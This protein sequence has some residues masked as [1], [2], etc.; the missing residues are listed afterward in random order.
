MRKYSNDGRG[1]YRSRDG[2]L[3]GVC[4]GVADYF[5]LS[6][7]WVRMAV[8]LVFLLSGFWPVLGVYLVAALLM[9][10]R[11]VRPIESEDEQEFYDSY[12]HS[13]RSAAQR[14]KRQFDNIDRRIRRMESTVTGKDYDWERRFNS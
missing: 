9:K 6:V 7:F 5:D 3:L 2:V 12:V 11:P 10:P 4:R 1:L 8:V 14:L 13:P